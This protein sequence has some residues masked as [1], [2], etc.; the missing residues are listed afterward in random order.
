MET[1][2][3][4]VALP[5]GDDVARIVLELRLRDALLHLVDPPGELSQDFDARARRC[6]CLQHL[7]HD[8]GADEHAVKGCRV[9]AVGGCQGLAEE[10][11]LEIGLERLDLP[12]KVVPVDAHGQ[13]ADEFLAALFGGV[14]LLGEED[15]T[16][17]GAPGRLLLDPFVLSV[18]HTPKEIEGYI[19]YEIPELVEKIS[20]PRDEGYRGAL[21]TGDDERIARRQRRRGAHLDKGEARAVGRRLEMLGGAPEEGEVLGEAALQAEDADGEGGGFHGCGCVSYPVAQLRVMGLVVHGMVKIDIPKPAASTHAKEYPNGA[22]M[23]KS[24]GL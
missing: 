19:L 23:S 21:A 12:A 16:S 22:K 9:A 2:P 15:E 4:N 10:G 6:R 3:Q 24:Q 11:E 1:H 5:H 18:D 7:L 13:A 17:A 8:G 20:L 14:C